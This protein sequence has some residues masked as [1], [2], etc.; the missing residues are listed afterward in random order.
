MLLKPSIALPVAAVAALA[1]ELGPLPGSSP[2]GALVLSSTVRDTHWLE[3]LDGL[4]LVEDGEVTQWLAK[5]LSVVAW[6]DAVFRIEDTSVDAPV[7]VMGCMAGNSLVGWARHEGHCSISGV[8]SRDAVVDDLV[9][10]I[11][12][13]TDRVGESPTLEI[14]RNV[15]E[16]MDLVARSATETAVDPALARVSLSVMTAA[17]EG[18]AAV[19]EALVADRMLE[20]TR[21]GLVFGEALRGWEDVVDSRHRLDV[22]RLD[23]QGSEDTPSVRTMRFCGSRANRAFMLPDEGG[24]LFVRPL[25]AEA[26]ELLDAFLTPQVEDA[27]SALSVAAK[28]WREDAARFGA[29][30][31]V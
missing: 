5:A 27:S 11:T 19:I 13:R 3:V 8:A 22:Q 4:G 26:S 31:P 20:E 16:A 30:G 29:G 25:A 15:L 23:V 17:N 2:L 6:P 10:R 1:D 9:G 21:A 7:E 14:P 24:A 28:T 18:P 12:T